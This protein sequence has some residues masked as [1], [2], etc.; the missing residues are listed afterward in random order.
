M[1]NYFL[2]AGKGTTSK[3][4]VLAT[5]PRLSWQTKICKKCVLQN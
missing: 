2:A 5:F 1:I 3:A 4:S